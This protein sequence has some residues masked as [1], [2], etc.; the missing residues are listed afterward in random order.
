MKSLHVAITILLTLG[1]SM[2]ASADPVQ[3]S[4]RVGRPAPGDK[5]APTLEQR[6]AALEAENAAL[7]EVIEVSGTTVKIKATGQLVLESQGTLNAKSGTGL[8]INAGTTLAASSAGS[9]EVKA[10][11]VLKLIGA[12][13]ETN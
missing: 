5:A 1:A 11:G 3:S 13:V 4:D 10:A 7:R 6:V 2:I 9:A 8:T 12:T